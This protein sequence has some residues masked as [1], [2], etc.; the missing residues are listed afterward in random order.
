MQM[1]RDKVLTPLQCPQGAWHQGSFPPL[2]DGTETHL[3]WHLRSKAQL[4]CSSQVEQTTPNRAFYTQTGP[5]SEVKPPTLHSRAFPRLSDTK[6]KLPTKR[7]I[8]L[9]TI[10]S[11]KVAT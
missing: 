5:I 8:Y 7:T 11:I 10:A 1:A 3:L 4:C 9:V 2:A 6:V